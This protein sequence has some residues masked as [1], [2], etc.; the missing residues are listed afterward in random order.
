M[1]KPNTEKSDNTYKDTSRWFHPIATST[2]TSSRLFS[3]LTQVHLFK[4]QNLLFKIWR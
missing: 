3:T 4:E 2:T 1:A